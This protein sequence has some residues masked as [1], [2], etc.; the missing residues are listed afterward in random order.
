[1]ENSTEK[2][3]N[4]VDIGLKQIRESYVRFRL[5]DPRAE[6]RMGESVRKYGQ[7]TPGIVAETAGED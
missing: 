6:Q 5:P 4:A 3:H 2:K 7:M 1:M